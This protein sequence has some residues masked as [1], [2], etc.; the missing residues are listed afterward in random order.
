MSSEPAQAHYGLV[1][2]PIR[3]PLNIILRQV[4]SLNIIRAIRP[5]VGRDTSLWM[6]RTAY[7]QGL[8]Q[9]LGKDALPWSQLAGKKF[10]QLVQIPDYASVDRA[11][12]SLRLGK[13]EFSEEPGLLVFDVEECFICSG[14]MGLSEP[15]CGF[16]GGLLVSVVNRVTG[17]DLFVRETRCVAQNHPSCRFELEFMRSMTSD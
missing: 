1:V 8:M 14:L 3:K 2:K 13:V 7:F 10:G 11:F 17:R 12:R 16:V 15:C 9:E 6:F 5:R 4:D